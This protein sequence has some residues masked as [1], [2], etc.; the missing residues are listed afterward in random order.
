MADESPLGFFSGW[1]QSRFLSAIPPALLRSMDVQG[2]HN[3][4]GALKVIALG[5]RAAG[6]D[7]EAIRLLKDHPEIGEGID[8]ML[9]SVRKS[10]NTEGPSDEIL[11]RMGTTLMDELRPAVVG[12]L[13]IQQLLEAVEHCCEQLISKVANHKDI[14][15]GLPAELLDCANNATECLKFCVS[16]LLLSFT[17]STSGKPWVEH[18]CLVKSR[19]GLMNARGNLR[20]HLGRIGHVFASRGEIPLEIDGR[21]YPS[22]FHAVFYISGSAIDAIAL[23]L[24]PAGQFIYATGLAEPFAVSEQGTR[25]CITVGASMLQLPIAH[26]PVLLAGIQKEV[27]A[28]ASQKGSTALPAYDPLSLCERNV[29]EA[30]EDEPLSGAK[31]AEAAGYPFTGRF[32]ETLSSMKARQLLKSG[33]NNRGYLRGPKC[34]DIVR[35]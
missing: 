35:T 7:A 6:G 33:P 27:S 32:R 9:E 23:A 30:L 2:L 3:A 17:K 11:L 20:E 10:T 31:L 13:S 22:A 25:E 18:A 14:L 1:D 4:D 28:A 15:G 29:L 8:R 19:K 5:M 26:F 12:M 21:A 34:P 24:S 16:L